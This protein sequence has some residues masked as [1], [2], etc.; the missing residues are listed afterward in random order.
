MSNW[1]NR[2][3]GVGEVDPETLLANPHNWRIHPKKQKESLHAV[4]GD[5]GWGSGIIV[6]QRTG[7]VVDGHLRVSLA[8]QEEEELIPVQFV[9]LSEE[10]EKTILATLDPIGALAV[11]DKE[12]LTALLLQMEV[13]PEIAVIIDTI[14]DDDI[15][16]IILTEPDVCTCPYCGNKHRREN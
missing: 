7:F 11:V 5:I 14:T 8:L 9:D 4:L 15:K 13:S 6:N 10:E 1:Q 12:K 3:I 2:I 16:P